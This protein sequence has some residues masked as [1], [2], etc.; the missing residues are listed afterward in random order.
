MAA[1]RIGGQTFQP[2][3]CACVIKQG[4]YRDGSDWATASVIAED[5]VRHCDAPEHQAITDAED[6][7]AAIRLE[8]RPFAQAR[9]AIR[10]AGE[11]ELVSWYIDAD[12]AVHVHVRNADA[13][14]HTALD[15]ITNVI[16]TYL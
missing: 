7:S 15:A 9:A 4:I 14:L 12:R 5:I 1:V 13:G 2:A 11:G 6:L 10:A 8:N 3:T 16:P